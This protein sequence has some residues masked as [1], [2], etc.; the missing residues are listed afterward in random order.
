MSQQFGLQ[1]EVVN[2]EAYRNAITRFRESNVRL[3]KFSE[4]RDPKTMP[5]SIQSGLASV[6]P[7]QPHPLNLNKV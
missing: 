4:L 6:D 2:P 3:P 1:T 5:E 7:D